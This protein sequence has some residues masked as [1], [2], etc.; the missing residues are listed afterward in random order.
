MHD[1]IAS[2]GDKMSPAGSGLLVAS[3]E[4]AH[5]RRILSGSVECKQ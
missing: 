3:S 2:V 5:G 1:T 4:D